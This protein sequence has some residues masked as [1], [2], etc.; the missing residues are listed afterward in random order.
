METLVPF[1]LS[2]IAK[3]N[4]L[5]RTKLELTVVIWAS[6]RPA[7]TTKNFEKGVIRRFMK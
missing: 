6:M 5:L 1:M 3:E 2:T 4:T 7:S